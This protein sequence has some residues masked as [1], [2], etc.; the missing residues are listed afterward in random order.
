MKNVVYI[1]VGVCVL[2]IIAYV[3]F[4]SYKN[5]ALN[6]EVAELREALANRDTILQMQNEA[7]LQK[8]LE[9]ENYKK[10]QEQVKEKIITRYKTIQ[11]DLGT[12]SCEAKLKALESQLNTFFER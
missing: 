4:I 12:T 7:I 2:A 9:V 3:G 6:S 5:N 11:V 8:A 10:A 1:I